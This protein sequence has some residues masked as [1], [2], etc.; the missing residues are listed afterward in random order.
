MMYTTFF[1]S[2]RHIVRRVVVGRNIVQLRLDW[3]FFEEKWV[4]SPQ[5]FLQSTQMWKLEISFPKAITPAGPRGSNVFF[6]V[7]SRSYGKF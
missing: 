4:F 3:M 1:I 5:I 6:S 2:V 7:L